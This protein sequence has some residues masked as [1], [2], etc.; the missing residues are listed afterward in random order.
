VKINPGGKQLVFYRVT[1]H[2]VPQKGNNSFKNFIKFQNS[3]INEKKYS[4]FK[5]YKKFQNFKNF[6]KIQNF[7][8]KSKFQNVF[9]ISKFQKN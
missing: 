4:K 2:C 8:K 9:N 6:K 5:N 7:H 1:T 3:K